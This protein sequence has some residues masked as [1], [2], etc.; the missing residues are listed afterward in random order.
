MGLHSRSV[1]LF[2]QRD[3]N[4]YEAE[5]LT[6]ILPGYTLLELWQ[7]VGLLEDT[8]LTISVFVVIVGLFTM[9]IILMS[10]INER[11]REMAIFRAIGAKPAHIFS[12]ILMEATFITLSGIALG[13]LFVS[14]LIFFG[15]GALA[16]D[17]GLFVSTNW[18]NLELFF[19][20][21]S[22]AVLGFFIGMIPGLLNY[23]HSLHD[24]MS[25]RN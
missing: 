10:S 16:R 7:V 6:A 19:I 21:V 22:V 2:L 18:I 20:L 23:R 12:L 3:F 15:Q 1:A 8:L 13:C 11:R 5:P 24:G 17:F 14:A 25:V 9:L 4:Q